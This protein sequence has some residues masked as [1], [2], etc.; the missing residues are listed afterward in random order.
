MEDA[1]LNRVILQ[2]AAIDFDYEA[3]REAGTVSEWTVT[4]GL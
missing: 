2:L 1:E 4:S 3:M